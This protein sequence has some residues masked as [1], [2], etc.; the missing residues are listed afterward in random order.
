MSLGKR[1]RF[2][3]NRNAA[4]GARIS[5]EKGELGLDILERDDGG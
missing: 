1:L 2:A 4:N 5:P 3:F